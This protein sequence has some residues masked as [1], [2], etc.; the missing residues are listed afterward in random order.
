MREREPVPIADPVPHRNGD[1][2]VR[3]RGTTSR[4]AQEPRRGARRSG[5]HKHGR[6]RESDGYPPSWARSRVLLLNATFEPLTAVPLKR[7]IVL[8]VCGK[9]E[10][11]HN[12]P[13]GFVLHSAR[14][15][16]PVPSVIRLGNYVRVPYRAQVP[17]TRA[18]IMHR[19]RFRCAYCGSKATTV[20]HVVPRSRG[21]A[22]TWQNC[23]ACCSKCNHRKADRLLAELGWTLRT[24][25]DA[26][27]GPYWRLLTQ[28]NDRDADWRPYLGAPAA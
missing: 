16:I 14:T 17:L 24:V 21:G 7:A 19:D 12:D 23:V 8:V 20:D 27:R 28:I 3:E 2:S 26:P 4:G 11:V 22:H 5:G 9:A 15:A 10:I 25:P 1:I 18:G 6:S 13:S